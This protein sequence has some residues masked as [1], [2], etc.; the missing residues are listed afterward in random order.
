MIPQGFNHQVE[1]F[2]SAPHWYVAFSGG[3]DSHVLLVLLQQTLSQLSSQNISPLPQLTAVHINH[4]LQRESGHWAAHCADICLALDIP[5]LVERVDV[6]GAGN[7]EA[8]ARDARYSVFESLLQKNDVLFMGHHGNDQ[9]ETF[10]YRLLRGAGVKG[11][12]G[13]AR[14]RPLAAGLLC[15]PLLLNSQA[16]IV[17]IAK[18]QQLQWIEDPSNADVKFDRNWLRHQLLPP[19]LARWPAADK[20]VQRFMAHLQESEQLLHELAVDDLQHCDVQVDDFW[21]EQHLSIK[22]LQGFSVIRQKNVLRHWAQASLSDAQMKVL[23]AQ[24]SNQNTDQKSLLTVANK[25]FRVFQQRLFCCDTYEKSQALTWQADKP[26]LV[27]GFGYLSLSC[28]QA[29]KLNI[30]YRQGG[31]VCLMPGHQQHKSL[32]NLL[33]ELAVP[34]WHRG[35]LPLIY[36]GDELLAVADI[37]RTQA[38]DRVLGENNTITCRSH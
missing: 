36:Y 21:H 25:S 16:E 13:M 38:A 29:L 6:D 35:R 11:L 7:I 4:Q 1:A 30:R 12:S 19:L 31:E 17:A 18:Q 28:P 5:L 9:L 15:R 34:P 10:F 3:V 24:L 32:K 33:Q 23:T 37:I 26:V 22:A 20:T 14:S 2:L 27:A 8:C